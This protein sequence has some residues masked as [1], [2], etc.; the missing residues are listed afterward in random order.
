[1][2]DWQLAQ[3]FAATPLTGGALADALSAVTRTAL[4]H[5]ADP[6][7]TKVE[8]VDYAFGSPAT[9]ALL[10]V[11]GE[12]PAGEPWTL[13]CKLLHHARHWRDLVLLPPE[14]A[15]T[16]QRDFPWR[17]ELDL[18]APEMVPTFPDGLRPPDLHLLADLGD[19]RCAVWMEYVDEAPVAWDVPRFARAAELLGR[20][21]ARS[22]DPG[23]LAGCGFPTGFALRMYAGR[24]VTFRGLMPLASDELWSHPWL[25]PHADLR[26][27]LRELGPRI[28]EL[29]DRLDA[30][31]QCLPH[32]DASPQNL[33]VPA[34]APDT[35][36]AIDISFRS[37]HAVGFDLSQLLV[38]LVHAR[39][40]P[41]DRMPEIADAVLPAYVDGLRAEGWSG[42]PDEVAWAFAVVALLRSGFDGFRY[43]LLVADPGDPGHADARLEFDERVAMS[44]FLAG[45]ARERL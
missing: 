39:L 17:A 43:D 31:E 38:G 8:P 19:D 34:S 40:L 29:L 44:R 30:L 35:F 33:L 26:G 10:R 28:P 27:L 13:F 2:T 1:M 42:D 37:P 15:V 4:G 20:W 11:R 24:A 3:L 32:G 25:A 12:S 41:P 7:R 21:N 23:L 5:D 6:A 14:E 45:R 16:F 9:G 22:R 36:V 18:W